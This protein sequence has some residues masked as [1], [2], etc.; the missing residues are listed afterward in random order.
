MRVSMGTVI[1]SICLLLALAN[2]VLAAFGKSP[3]PFEDETVSE[4]ASLIVTAA[5]SIAAWWK[6]NSFTKAAIK[7]DKQLKMEKE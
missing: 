5:A 7:A 2:Q 6:N 1:R 4:M 3:L